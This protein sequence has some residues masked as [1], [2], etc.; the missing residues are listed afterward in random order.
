MNLG[1]TQPAAKR[2]GTSTR[3]RTPSLLKRTAAAPTGNR[4]LLPSAYGQPRAVNKNSRTGPSIRPR[5]D[6][7]NNS[8]LGDAIAVRSKSEGKPVVDTQ[9]SARPS[10]AMSQQQAHRDRNDG[11]RGTRTVPLEPESRR[12]PRTETPEPSERAVGRRSLIVTGTANLRRR[13]KRRSRRRYVQTIRRA[14]VHRETN[15]RGIH[16]ASR[17]GRPLI[18]GTGRSAE[19]VRIP[20][21]SQSRTSGPE[22]GPFSHGNAEC[23]VSRVRTL[24]SG[25]SRVPRELKHITI[26]IQRNQQGGPEYW[27]RKRIESDV[28]SAL[29]RRVVTEGRASR[30]AAR[31]ASRLK[32]RR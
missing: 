17:P 8:L 32:G 5:P 4:R 7:C 9:D 18:E 1:R 14:T 28:E 6:D 19:G 15:W 26:G 20:P 2:G 12:A 23:P 24:A 16:E 10:K 13:E 25:S 30:S 29:T 3:Y 27:R 31:P 21:A 22:Q 11:D